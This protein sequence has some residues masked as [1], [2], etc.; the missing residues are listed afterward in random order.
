MQFR[1]LRGFCL[2]GG[3]DVTPGEIITLTEQGQIRELLQSGR[4]ATIT[5]DP[6][7]PIAAPAAVPAVKKGRKEK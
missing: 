3:I 7:E 6:H 1:T 2:G 4:I 5:E